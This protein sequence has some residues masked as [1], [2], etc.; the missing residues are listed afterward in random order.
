M[1]IDKIKCDKCDVTEEGN[2]IGGWEKVV[3]NEVTC[4]LC[5][6]CFVKYKMYVNDFIK[7]K[8]S[9]KNDSP[10]KK[11]NTIMNRVLNNTFDNL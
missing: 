11:G 9:V 2:N 3:F 4:D 7:I 6:L 1:K 5:P 10:L 8:E